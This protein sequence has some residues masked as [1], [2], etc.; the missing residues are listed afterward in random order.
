MSFKDI[1]YS[2]TS[3][4]SCFP[5]PEL[6]IN[7]HRFRIIRLLGEGGFAYVYLVESKPDSRSQPQL[8]AVKKIRCPFGAE[9]VCSA[10]REVESYKIFNHSNR[11]SDS[12][13]VGGVIHMVGWCVKQEPDG[14]KTVYIILPYLSKGNLQDQINQHAIEGRIYDERTLRTLFK[15]ICESLMV[16]HHHRKSRG[17]NSARAQ[18]DN[19]DD[20]FVISD[21]DFDN[22]NSSD[23]NTHEEQGENFP[24][25][26][27]DIKPANIMLTDTRKPILMDLGSCTPARTTVA[28]RQAALQLQDFAAE[29]CT[30]P[31]RAP[32][33]FDVKTG[34]TLD[35]RVD[36]WSLGC[37]FFALMYGHSPFE[38]TEAN[39]GAT[40]S[41][42]IMNGKY[43]FPSTPAYSSGLKEIIEMCLVVDPK[44][45]PFIDEVLKKVEEL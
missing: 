10:L 38:L 25:I 34:Q 7:N 31:Y 40:L 18:V 12:N 27:G 26:H 19:D 24:Y 17:D 6:Q 20:E 41:M 30:M 15:G 11:V 3:C 16:M 13:T 22:D 14:S 42:A 1:L 45:R 5:D 36:I 44:E 29:H 4:L 33:L 35:E 8:F 28:T 9:S 39:S 23:I 2:I 21:S 32:E 43:K 37:T